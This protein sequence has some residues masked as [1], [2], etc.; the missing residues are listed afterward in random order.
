MPTPSNAGPNGTPGG[1]RTP[2]PLLLAS[3]YFTRKEADP[4]SVA[5]ALIVR[6]TSS[7]IKAADEASRILRVRITDATVDRYRDVVDPKGGD[8]KNFKKNPVVPW[9][10]DYWGMPIARDTGLEVEDDAVYGNPQFP[11]AEL[12]GFA[13]TVYRMA[14]AGYLNAASIGFMPK[15]WTYDEDRRG[16]NIQRWEL[17]EY[18]IVPIPANPSCLI[19]ARAAGIDIAP[20]AEWAEQT[21]AGV[22]G[23]GGWVPKED[24]EAAYF[25]AA[26][27]KKI[28]IPRGAL[29]GIDAA[30]VQEVLTGATELRGAD[31]VV[32]RAFVTAEQLLAD[33]AAAREAGGDAAEGTEAAAAEAPATDAGGTEQPAEQAGAAGTE[34]SAADA[35]A[36]AAPAAIDPAKALEVAIATPEGARALEAFLASRGVTLGAAGTAP[37]TAEQRISIDP[38]VFRQAAKEVVTEAFAPI[39]AALTSAT[40]HLG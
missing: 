22:R 3:E 17:W 28:F 40:G 39:Q 21:L 15:E 25:I 38:A 34:A 6:A 27:E 13:D 37:P 14:L 35:G 20:I 9:A 5:D 18:S 16:Y 1:T 10:H 7:Q 24:A 36:A 11:E 19:E 2:R 33:A 12:H 32:L 4:A 23:V 8:F 30:D 31:G 29:K 26:G